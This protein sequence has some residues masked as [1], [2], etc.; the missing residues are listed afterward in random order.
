[1][2]LNSLF[3]ADVPLSNYYSL[4]THSWPQGVYVNRFF[5]SKYGVQQA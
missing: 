1:M 2:A 5:K 4:L 3:C